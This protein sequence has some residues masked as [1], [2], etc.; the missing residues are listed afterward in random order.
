MFFKRKLMMPSRLS[1]KENS[2]KRINQKKAM[3]IYSEM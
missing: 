3:K 2:S 1:N